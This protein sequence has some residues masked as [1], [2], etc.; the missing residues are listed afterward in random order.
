[1]RVRNNVLL[2]VLDPEGKNLK[3]PVSASPIGSA[4]SAGSGRQATGGAAGATP[5]AGFAGAKS[6]RHEASGPKG[7]SE[8]LV[9]CS[10]FDLLHTEQG[11]VA[12]EQWYRR[13]FASGSSSA[14]SPLPRADVGLLWPQAFC[15]P[16]ALHEYA[17]LELLKAFVDCSDSEAFDF[18]ELWDYDFLGMLALPQVYLAMCLVAALGSRQLLKFLYFHSTWLFKALAK[19]SLEW[20]GA[21]PEPKV[22]WPRVLML[23]R[24]VGAPGHLVSRIGSE[25]GVASPGFSDGLTYDEFLEV[26]FPILAQLDR[27]AEIGESTVI[28]ESDRMVSGEQ[29]RSRTCTIL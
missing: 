28:N 1:M 15:P 21:A 8:A 12:F 10:A 4:R 18:F 3:K 2:A 14:A 5:S 20:V 24:L 11:F 22:G 29:M 7:E 17:F 13:V 19:G 23:L 27:G 26:M 16:S 9:D 25:N 6:L